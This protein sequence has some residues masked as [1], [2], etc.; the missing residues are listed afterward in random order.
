MFFYGSDADR[1]RRIRR[2]AARLIHYSDH[3]GHLHAW[4][5]VL[6]VV[7]GLLVV[8]AS[9]YLIYVLEI[10]RGVAISRLPKPRPDAKPPEAPQEPVNVYRRHV[11]RA[12]T[13]SPD[14]RSDRE[15]AS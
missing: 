15:G 10:F 1:P 11:G 12:E 4:G 5:T 3:H 13:A 9:V 2:G 7:L 6:V 14:A 8:I